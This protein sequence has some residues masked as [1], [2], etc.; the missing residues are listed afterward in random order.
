ME[1]NVFLKFTGER[2]VW[3][4]RQLQEDKLFKAADQLPCSSAPNLLL[5]GFLII[6]FL[7]LILSDSIFQLVVDDTRHLLFVLMKS[8]CIQVG[9]IK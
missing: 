6:F 4:W 1:L 8:G 7:K 2:L 5:K 9:A 3:D